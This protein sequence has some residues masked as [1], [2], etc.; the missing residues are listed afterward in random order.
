MDDPKAVLHEYLVK[1]RDALVWKLDGL[2]T[3][4]RRRPLVPTGTSL[5]GLVKHTASVAVGYL[6]PTFGRDFPDPPAWFDDEVG[7]AD[8]WVTAEETDDDILDF[9]RRAWAFC[10]ETIAAMPLDGIGRVPW[11]DEEDNTVTLHLVL[12]HLTAEVNRHAGHADLVRELIDG[13]AGLRADNDNLFAGAG[14]FA[15]LHERIE[16][17]ARAAAGR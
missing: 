1:A 9:H 17:A 12:V 6:G 16:R 8:M 5:L 3:Y 15:E 10:D 14:G 4:D 13:T 11:W 2:S 7:N